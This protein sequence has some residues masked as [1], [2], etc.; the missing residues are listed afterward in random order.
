MMTK[1]I[2]GVI[3]VLLSTSAAVSA[4][5][6]N[7]P[8]VREIAEMQTDVL[9]AFYKLAKQSEAAVIDIEVRKARFGNNKVADASPC[10]KAFGDLV[11]A[12]EQ[13]L[14]SR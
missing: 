9:R 10:L 3:A 2:A 7:V 8:T 11:G 4:E 5:E 14:R 6:C 12:F 13:E 1:T